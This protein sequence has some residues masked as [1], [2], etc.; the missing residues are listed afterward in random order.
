[1]AYSSI[2]H[3]TGDDQS[4]E[5]KDAAGKTWTARGGA[6]IATAQYKF[7]PSSLYCDA[8]NSYVDTPAHADFNLAGLS[9]WT[10]HFWAYF[11]AD[12]VTQEICG[13]TDSGGNAANSSLWFRRSAVNNKI[14]VYYHY[15]SSVL[16]IDQPTLTAPVINTWTHI[17]LSKW[18][19]NA[20]LFIRGEEGA[21]VDLTGITINNSTNKWAIGRAGEYNA[22]L[23]NAYVDEFIF[24][25][26]EALWTSDFTPP[27]KAL[28]LSTIPS[29]SVSNE[30]R[31]SF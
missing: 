19:N 7:A 30:V 11:L 17:A 31:V 10:V 16:T 9:A 23:L 2:L 12:G 28:V 1:M 26:G 29:M 24:K 20:K 15:G 6:K 13:Q 8:V 18:G 27:D 4:T 3:F 25:P 14:L 5:I 21:L 22:N